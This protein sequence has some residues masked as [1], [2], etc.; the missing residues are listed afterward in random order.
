MV[1]TTN[2]RIVHSSYNPENGNFYSKYG[3]VKRII[4]CRRWCYEEDL[5]EQVLN[6]INS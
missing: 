2:N 1:L 6:D 4:N 5:A 3:W